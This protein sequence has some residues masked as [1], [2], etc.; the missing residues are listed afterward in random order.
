MPSPESPLTVNSHWHTAHV[1]SFSWPFPPFALSTFSCP[2]RV[3]ANAAA[4]AA[5]AAA[6]FRW[7]V[8]ATARRNSNRSWW[9]TSRSLA[10]AAPSPVVSL[11]HHVWV[12]LRAKQASACCRQAAAWQSLSQNQAC[13]QRE[14]RFVAS[15]PQLS[16]V[17][18]RSV[19]NFL[20]MWSTSDSESG[21]ASEN[22]ASY[23]FGLRTANK[24]QTTHKTNQS[25]L[26]YIN[27]TNKMNKNNQ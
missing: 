17:P 10:P 6:F 7:N 5:A 24:G 2:C 4:A 25:K 27:K 15:F 21:S 3:R 13:W 22:S 14:Q 26:Q 12:S 18:V 9:I 8:A 20:S 19:H 1:S 11:P 16:Q 23:F